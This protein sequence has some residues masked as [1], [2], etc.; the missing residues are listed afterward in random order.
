MKLFIQCLIKLRSSILVMMV[1][2]A[3]F[4]PTENRLHTIETDQYEKSGLENPVESNVNI[5][6]KKN[7]KEKEKLGQL[8]P[9]L[10]MPNVDKDEI[11][12]DLDFDVPAVQDTANKEERKSINRSDSRDRK[13]RKSRS[14]SHERRRKH[15][16]SISSSDSD[17]RERRHNRRR[18]ENRHKD[19]SDERDYDKRRRS[20]YDRRR[21]RS[22]SSERRD[23]RYKDR[24]HSEINLEKLIGNIYRGLVK[25]VPQYGAFIS[26]REFGRKHGL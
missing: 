22:H 1:N 17:S 14:R 12:L 24:H 23:R 3:E 19:R 20:R 9:S 7:D 25:S 26:C 6:E 2:K 11:N 8:F 21:S 18:K 4:I 16:K 13:H 15:R 10:A 5:E